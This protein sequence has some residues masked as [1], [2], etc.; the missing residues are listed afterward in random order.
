MATRCI[1]VVAVVLVVMGCTQ[2]NPRACLD[3]ICP[4][5]AFPYCDFDGS[6]E[7]AKQTCVA[8]ECTAGDFIGCKGAE[9]LRCNQAGTNYKTTSC[10][11]GCSEASGGCRMCEP[12]Q[13][14]CTNGRVAT[15]DAA[16]NA[17]SAKACPLGCFADQPRCRDADP[18]NNLASTS[19]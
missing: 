6:L 9:E 13:T 8:V 16:G 7:G 10:E 11:L 1:G 2:R 12:N 15:C 4:D 3:G 17:V 19:T 14:A 18:S 5:P